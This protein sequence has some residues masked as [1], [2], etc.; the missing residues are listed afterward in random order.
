MMHT[1]R[2]VRYAAR[3]RVDAL[4]TSHD[5]C[6]QELWRGGGKGAHAGTF[7]IVVHGR[8][9]M[10]EEGVLL[11][12]PRGELRR[13]RCGQRRGVEGECK[14]MGIDSNTKLSVRRATHIPSIPCVRAMRACHVSM[15]CVHTMCPYHAS[16]PHV[17][18]MRGP[19]SCITS[20]HSMR[21]SLTC[22]SNRLPQP[23]LPM[24]IHNQHSQWTSTTST[25]S[26]H[27]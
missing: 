5:R 25:P 6:M 23:A 27:P 17:H 10:G 19:P 14:A 2:R 16:I 26:G 1:H 22:V 11:S 18:T 7:P 15:P 21:A 24:D 3:P 9:C 20:G 13:S 12:R 8:A 4:V